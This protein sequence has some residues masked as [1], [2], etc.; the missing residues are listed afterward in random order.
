M[1]HAFVLMELRGVQ[2][3][4]DIKHIITLEIKP[5]GD[6]TFVQVRFLETPSAVACGAAANLNGA[7]VIRLVSDGNMA[8]DSALRRGVVAGSR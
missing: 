2:C 3:R 7:A 1:G 6:P 5:I 4:G 8:C